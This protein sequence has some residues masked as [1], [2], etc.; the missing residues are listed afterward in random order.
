MPLT[1][2][3]QFHLAWNLQLTIDSISG[4]TRDSGC[5]FRESEISRL[6]GIKSELN[7]T[8]ERAMNNCLNTNLLCS[9]T[10]KKFQKKSEN[11]RKN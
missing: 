4:N 10:K 6:V 3:V 9:L 2:L 5:G 7:Q 11:S 1:L 8:T